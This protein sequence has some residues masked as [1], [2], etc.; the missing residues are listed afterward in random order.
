MHNKPRLQTISTKQQYTTYK[1]RKNLFTIQ[2]YSLHLKLLL[3]GDIETNLGPMPNILQ[4]HPSTHRNKC[5]RY[6][7]EC[8]IKLQLEYQHLAKKISPIINLTHP[9]HQDL[10]MDYLYLSRYIHNKQHH[11]PPHILYALITTISLV[12]ETCNHILIQIPNPDW[13]TAVLER[14]ALLQNPP[15]R[16]ILTMHPY[17]QSLQTNQYLISPPN[18]IHKELYNFIK[19][20][21]IPLTIQ[22][23]TH[24]FP[25]LPRKLLT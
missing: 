6:F 19:Q 7:I 2:T 5:K 22:I 20:S 8:T 10:V 4:T 25:F 1:K 21:N 12:I 11:P 9:K 16:H 18:T 23:I 15:E 24:K 14:M 17:S 13:T 3:N